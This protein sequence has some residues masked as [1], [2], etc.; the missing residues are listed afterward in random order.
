M[1]AG[2]SNQTA[3]STKVAIAPAAMATLLAATLITG[4]VAGIVGKSAVDLLAVNE[5]A[6]TTSADT[7]L[8]T[9]A[10]QVAVGRGPLAVDSGTDRL[11]PIVTRHPIEHGPLR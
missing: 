7:A 8:T 3:A 2:I 10:A 1:T 11:F 5:A 4:A 6:V 9:R